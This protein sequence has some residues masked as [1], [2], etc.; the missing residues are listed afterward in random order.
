MIAAMVLLCSAVMTDIHKNDPIPW[1]SLQ[2]NTEA[3][4]LSDFSDNNTFD[5][6][7]I[8][9]KRAGR[10]IMVEAVVDDEAG[11]LIFDSGATGLVLNRTYFR[12]HI[13]AAQVASN[14]IT[15]TVSEVDEIMVDKL[16]VSSLIFT[17]SKANLADLGHI[18]N[19]R[20]VKVLGLFGFGLL[21]NFEIQI[22]VANGQL[23]LYRIDRK[24]NRVMASN[25]FKA[26]YTQK[27]DVFNNIVFIKGDIGG[28]ELQ[29][30]LDTGAETNA[31]GTDA[32]NVVLKTITIQRKSNLKGAGSQ[33]N[34]ILY[35]IMNDFKLSSTRLHS[36]ETIVSNL[37]HLS[38]AYGMHID[39]MLGFN[40]LAKGIIC[41]NFGKKQ[42]AMRFNNSEDL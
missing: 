26:D 5:S 34:Q 27:M 37:D 10:L 33:V 30:C 8:P 28:K 23:K 3:L 21:R 40:F 20:G 4:S 7:I 35:G 29:F 32:P 39:G 15:G 16:S 25:P 1:Q 31:I 6:L 42:F 36:M 24:G 13:S 41:I 11:N 22:D 18:E 14:G 12:N 19:R 9:L 17:K 2:M 38:E